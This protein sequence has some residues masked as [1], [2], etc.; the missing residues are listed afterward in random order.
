MIDYG[1]TSIF[2]SL[3]YSAGRNVCC[4]AWCFILE[5]SQAWRD[6]EIKFIQDPYSE[7]LRWTLS[8]TLHRF[9]IALMDVKQVNLHE[10]TLWRFSSNQYCSQIQRIVKWF[11]TTTINPTQ[12]QGPSC[13]VHA[14]RLVMNIKNQSIL[15]H[16]YSP[17]LHV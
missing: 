8:P 9:I 2:H 12:A 13:S 17:C 3:L 16:I 11:S 15:S 14:M 10:E 1:L 5:S 4:L 7:S 6:A